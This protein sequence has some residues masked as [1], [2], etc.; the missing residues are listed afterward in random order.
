VSVWAVSGAAGYGKTFR[1]MQRLEEELIA[2]PLRENQR[3]LALT[4]MHGSRRRLEQR[5]KDMEVLHRRYSCTTIDGFARTLRERWQRLATALEQPSAAESDFDP[6][7]QFAADLLER[8]AVL[9]WACTAYPIVIVD[10]AQDLDE[11]RLRI[12]AGFRQSACLLLAFDDFQCLEASRRPSPAALWIPTVCRPE[13]LQKPQRTG[14][15]ELLEAAAALRSG[16]VLVN[17]TNFKM[18]GCD[19][20]YPAAAMLAAQLSWHREKSIAIITPARKGNYATGLIHRVS[21]VAC[22]EKK[23][24]PHAITWDDAQSSSSDCVLKLEMDTSASIDAVLVALALLPQS[25]ASANL[26]RWTKRQQDV[27]GRSHVTRQELLDRARR[28]AAV[29]KSHTGR[30]ERGVR[31]MTVHQ[32]KNREFDGVVVLWPHVLRN[33]IEGKLRLLYNAVTRAKKWC[34]VIVQGQL[35]LQEPPFLPTM[36]ATDSGHQEQLPNGGASRHA[37]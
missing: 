30:A 22:G 2:N 21:T 27:L 32:A 23:H 8:D 6:Q 10:E 19:G 16:G 18:Q 5:L 31:A 34:L 12:V 13:E 28:H 33:D 26:I 4:Y 15:R 9:S 1:L 17:G 36:P 14:V 24:G 37:K 25:A 35:R 11:G 3:V 7:C 20:L 29:H